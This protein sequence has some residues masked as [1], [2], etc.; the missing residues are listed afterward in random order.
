MA[1][2]SSSEQTVQACNSCTAWS[3]LDTKG[4]PCQY[5]KK[6]P[7]TAFSSEGGWGGGVGVVAQMKSPSF[8]FSNLAEFTSF[9]G[10][11]EAA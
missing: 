11:G 1:A 7:E 3:P 5:F 10:G 8:F 6:T 4:L 2:E 9:R